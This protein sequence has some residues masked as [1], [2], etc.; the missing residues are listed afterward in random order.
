MAGGLIT[1]FFQVEYNGLLF[2]GDT[3]YEIV[4]GN[5]FDLPTMRTSD[6]NRPQRDGQFSGTDYMAGKSIQLQLEA[7]SSS[8][9]DL[10]IRLAA[11]MEAFGHQES[12]VGS[13]GRASSRSAASK[14][15]MSA[16]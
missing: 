12:S 5:H 13:R 15:S 10:G 16:S 8:D 7:W 11:L 4:R 6:V 3:G 1:D 2:G 9:V 14:V